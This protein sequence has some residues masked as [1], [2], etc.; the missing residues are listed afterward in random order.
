MTTIDHA[1]IVPFA[2]FALGLIVGLLAGFA[3]GSELAFRTMRNR[4]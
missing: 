3:I 2:C 1:A 4:P